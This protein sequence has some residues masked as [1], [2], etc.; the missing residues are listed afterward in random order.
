MEKKK[1]KEGGSGIFYVGAALLGL[2]AGFFAKKIY[3][4]VKEESKTTSGYELNLS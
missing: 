2:A 4:D 3:D 1:E